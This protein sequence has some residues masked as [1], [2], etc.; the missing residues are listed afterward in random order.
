MW[1]PNSFSNT[2]DINDFVSGGGEEGYCKMYMDIMEIYAPTLKIVLEH[3][4][5]RPQEPFLFHCAR[6]LLPLVS[7]S[8]FNH[9]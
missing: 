4:R 3:V 1:I 7:P 6:E 9:H 8:S 5:D 2:I